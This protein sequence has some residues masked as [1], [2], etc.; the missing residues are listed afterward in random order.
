MNTLIAISSIYNQLCET[1]FEMRLNLC[2]E[3]LSITPV[4][5]PKTLKN[6][7]G[8]H[9]VNSSSTKACSVLSNLGKYLN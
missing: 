3:T 1:S 5:D 4:R 7:Q 6:C 2:N 9:S 8:D